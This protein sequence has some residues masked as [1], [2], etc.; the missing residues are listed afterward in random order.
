MQPNFAAYT[1]LSQCGANIGK[2]VTMH[3]KDQNTTII[4][5]KGTID[6][7]WNCKR[8][9][10]AALAIM[11]ML[12]SLGR[13]TVTASA[14]ENGEEIIDAKILPEVQTVTVTDP[15]VLNYS[16]SALA[17]SYEY[18]VPYMYVTPFTVNHS[19]TNEDGSK[20]YSGGNFPEVFNLINTAKLAEGG[21]GAY[22]SI[23]AY[24][25]DASTGIKENSSYRRINL[26]DSTYYPSGAAGRIRAVV[27]HSFPMLNVAEIEK[28]ANAWF[29]S[30]GEE[31]LNQLQSGEAIVAT[32]TAIWKLA[33]GD[34]YTINAHFDGMQDLTESWLGDYL[35]QAIDVSAASQVETEHTAA[36]IERL[37]QYLYNL[38]PMGIQYDAVSDATLENPIYSA[39]QE[40]GGTYAIT[41]TADV[42]TMV[43]DGDQLMLSATCNGQ[44]QNQPVLA[45]GSYSFTF[46]GMKD[47]YEVLLEINGYQCGGDVYMFDA[48][49]E[50]GAS[51]SVVGYDSSRL[52]VH[53]EVLLTPDRILNIFK[54]T[55]DESGKMPL[56]NIMF[57][58]YKVATFAQLENGEV[59]LSQQ[60]TE[61]EIDK[62]KTIH[63][64]VTTLQ[65]NS[66]GMATY[67]FTEN[68]L[69]DGIYMIVELFSDATTGPVAP[70]F[71]A[72]HGT[73]NDGTAPVYT[74]NIN[75]KN[76]TETGPEIFKDVTEIDNDSDSFDV[77]EIHTWIIRGGIPAGI[78][79]A[80]K[81]E[82][83]DELDDRLTYKAGS[84]EIV[85]YTK[86]GTE[87]P[88]NSGD[89]Y[90]LTEA[91]NQFRISLTPAGMAYVANSQGEGRIKPE[92]RVY[93]QAVINE[94]ATMGESIPNDA[95]LDYT[96]SAGIDYDDDSDIPEVHTGGKHILKTDTSDVPLAGATFRIARLATEEEIMDTAVT[97]EILHVDGIDLTVVYVDFHGTVDMSEE[98]VTE[99]TTDG[100][101]KAVFYGLAYGEYYL[102]EIKAPAG[103]N[104]LTQPIH[105]T[106]NESS[107][108]TAADE[109]L[110]SSDQYV[111][112][113]LQI[114]NTK[115]ILPETGGMGTALFT[116]TGL[117]II[118]TAGMLLFLNRKKKHF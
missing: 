76:A 111:D 31:G 18:N 100:Q 61:Q 52:P 108:L 105:V 12:A 7:N 46:S 67:N 116:V 42:N 35:N 50:R 97:K 3:R 22:A 34:H 54:T 102:V 112:N 106:I 43:S 90:I 93:F 79:N 101:G 45:A 37:Y 70:F 66:Q 15:Y 30:R 63:N 72:V 13:V 49:G 84:P 88:M 55:S 73:A 2:G 41:V 1:T 107:H 113:T 32:Q 24:C 109:W 48:Y 86:A 51:Q 4:F 11:L 64:L 71:I 87:L 28:N 94:N 8:M 9:T 95:H 19:I 6:L 40:E 78:G 65:T 16:P 57:D 47:R 114:V 82:I 68:G 85:L 103:Y 33:N 59:I 99:I 75:P 36:N 117:G 26:E 27:M 29:A 62:Y 14:N 83:T 110:D 69:D 77:G 20:Y 39:I 21:T 25:T 53:G 23:A 60:P 38:E 118:G 91:E 74:L 5:Q 96:N 44:V 58:I 81:Y 80:Q 56:A 10:A 104:L 98:K 17:A 115:F 89:H 92:I